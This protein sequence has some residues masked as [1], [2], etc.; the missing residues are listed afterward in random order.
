MM[1][2]E[3]DSKGVEFSKNISESVLLGKWTWIFTSCVTYLRPGGQETGK[4]E[5]NVK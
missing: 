4:R 2:Y 1:S 5:C 3:I